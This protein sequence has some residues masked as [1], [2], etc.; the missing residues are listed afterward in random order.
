MGIRTSISIKDW[1]KVI[2][3]LKKGLKYLDRKH[4]FRNDYGVDIIITFEEKSYDLMR[5]YVL[6]YSQRFYCQPKRPN[7]CSL[8]IN[9][10]NHYLNNSPCALTLNNLL[11]GNENLT[12]KH[13]KD[14][15]MRVQRFI[16]ATKRFNP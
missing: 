9:Q 7:Q 10:R 14:I 3:D 12:F 15:F 2:Y 8:Y 5:A 1:E 6:Q 11:Y 16:S 4:D 13:N